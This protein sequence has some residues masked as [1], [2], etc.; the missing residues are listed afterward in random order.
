MP[1]GTREEVV[2]CQNCGDVVDPRRA[3]L[4]YDYCV[5]DECQQRCMKRVRL[6]AVGVNKAADY[7]MKA[8]EVL[9][10]PGPPRS[11]PSK[12]PDDPPRPTVRRRPPPATRKT[13]STLAKLRQREAELDAALEAV[14]QRFCRSEIT[15]KEMDGQ[16]DELIRAFNQAVRSENIRYRGM[17]RSRA[18]S[19][20]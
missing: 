4:G 19:H 7:Y 6:A 16:R 12:E 1:V 20:H 11:V 8:E 18:S 9:P 17:L 5:K 14:Y 3:K 15:A 13:K 2:K 10:L